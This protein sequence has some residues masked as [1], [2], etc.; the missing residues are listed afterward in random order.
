MVIS[1]SAQENV[2]TKATES[3]FLPDPVYVPSIASQLQNGTFVGIDPN[4]GPKLGQ[5]KKKGVNNVIPGKGKPDGDDALVAH[6]QRA[7]KK[8][9][10]EPI[11]VF[12]ANTAN[13]TPSDP[14][15]AVGPNHYLGSWNS[16]FRIFDKEGNPVKLRMII[17]VS[18]KL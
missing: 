3:G 9:S 2:A 10:K 14:T 1:V 11:L 12:N 8:S 18:F 16:G 5:P 6:Q 17:P 13:A 15:G 4:E 7:V